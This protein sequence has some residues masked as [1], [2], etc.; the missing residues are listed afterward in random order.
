MSLMALDDLT[1]KEKTIHDQG[2]VSL[3][4]QIHDE[5]D[6][7]EL[8]AFGWGDLAVGT[9]DGKTQGA[10]KEQEVLHS[11][12][13]HDSK[14]SVGVSPAAEP[15]ISGRDARAPLLTRLVALNHQSFYPLA[16]QWSGQS[17]IGVARG[18]LLSRQSP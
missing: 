6:D 8:K 15:E 16:R 3:L 9:Q 2:L 10:R 14:G 17:G 4:K 18:L 7:A 13:G 1:A 12:I 11:A 5:L